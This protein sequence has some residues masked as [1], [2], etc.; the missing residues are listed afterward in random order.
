MIVIDMNLM[1]ILSNIIVGHSRPQRLFSFGS[2]PRIT[3]SGQTWFSQHVKGFHFVFSANLISQIWQKVCES[4]S[5][6]VRQPRG[7]NSWCWPR[8]L[9][10]ME[11]RVIVGLES[12]ILLE[13][14]LLIPVLSIAQR[15]RYIYA[16]HANRLHMMMHWFK[17]ACGR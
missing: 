1:V 13:K 10:P 3:T 12:I 9:Q 14:C 6:S 2:G 15:Y 8:G 5:S 16:D 17:L 11:T 4:R 7:C